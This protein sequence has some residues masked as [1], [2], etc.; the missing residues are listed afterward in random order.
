[1]ILVLHRLDSG[2]IEICG[3]RTVRTTV[4]TDIKRF[5]NAIDGL[6]CSRWIERPVPRAQIDARNLLCLASV[7][8]NDVQ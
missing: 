1:M 2:F 5:Q 7:L 8:I 3:I 6:L 4:R